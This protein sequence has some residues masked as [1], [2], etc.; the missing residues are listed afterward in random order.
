MRDDVTGRDASVDCR[1][2]SR[3]SPLRDPKPGTLTGTRIPIPM[4]DVTDVVRHVIDETVDGCV[5][6]LCL[7]KLSLT[8]NRRA[9]G[10]GPRHSRP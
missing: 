5:V 10:R 7:L 9:R 1:R 2:V 6:T 3:W 8:G 4:D